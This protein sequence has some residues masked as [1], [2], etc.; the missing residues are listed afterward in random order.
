MTESTDL[1]RTVWAASDA[2]KERNDCTVK[3]LTITTGLPYKQVHAA[4]AKAGRKPR[5]GAHLATMKK[6]AES[7]GYHFESFRPFMAKTV[8]SAERDPHLLHG[9]FVLSTS[10]HVAAMVDGAVI[11][12]TKGRRHRVNTVFAVTP[13]RGFQAP[14]MEPVPFKPFRPVPV[15][16]VL[17]S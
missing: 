17:F 8:T 1:M 16:E 4:M 14:L 9:R 7:L 5:K 10:S 12:W 2:H 3:A 13:I 6:A 11:D 15:Q